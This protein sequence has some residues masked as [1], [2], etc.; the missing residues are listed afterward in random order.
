MVGPV[1][2]K[3]YKQIYITLN[4]IAEQIVQ[5]YFCEDG[6]MWLILILV[7]CLYYLIR[8]HDIKA[9]I[10]TAM[11]HTFIVQNCLGFITAT[12]GAFQII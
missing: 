5:D 8:P 1:V 6:D 2:V 3:V 12:M 9:N 11:D 10:I 4:H 7:N